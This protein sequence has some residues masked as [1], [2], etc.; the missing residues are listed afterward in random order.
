M[1]INVH[2]KKL[3]SGG[4]ANLT[5][6][7]QLGNIGSEVFRAI[8]WFKLKDDRFQNAFE[9]AL[10]LFDLTLTDNR[11]K[12]RRKEI[13]RSREVFCSLLTEPEKYDNLEHELD[14]LDNY[15]FRFGVAA[16]LQMGKKKV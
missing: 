16:R 2:H 4:W 8:K 1:R 11:W 14:S 15:F 5:L 3:A 7:E 9:R 12:G 13:A 10:E 6:M